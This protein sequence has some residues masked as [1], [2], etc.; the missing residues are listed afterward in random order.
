MKSPRDFSVPDKKAEMERSVMAL[1]LYFCDPVLI[2]RPPGIAASGGAKLFSATVTYLDLGGRRMLATSAHVVRYFETERQND[3]VTVFQLPGIVLRDLSPRL[4]DI[5]D[6]SDLATIDIGELSL[7]PRD[8]PREALQPRQFHVPTSWPP[9]AVTEGDVVAYAGWPGTL[10][11]D[12]ADLL[13]I[14]SNPYS[15]IGIPVTCALISRFN[16]KLD[17]SDMRLAFGRT[18]EDAKDYD[19]GGMSGGPVFR[20]GALSYELVGIIS[21]Y[22]DVLD[23]FV[24]T[25]AANI[26]RT[27]ALWHNTGR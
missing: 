18:T 20:R 10:R 2:G 3:G 6:A 14:E 16:V 17:R 9:D 27:G 11:R 25:S 5:D 23:Q 26:K 24:C 4:I 22:N 7:T 12:S 13:D 15:M 1:P 21:E 19:F 8:V